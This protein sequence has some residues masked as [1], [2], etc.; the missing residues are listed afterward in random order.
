[1]GNNRKPDTHT[2]NSKT[3][4]ADLKQ[5]ADREHRVNITYKFLT[6]NAVSLF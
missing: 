4:H 6:T 1:M 5:N 2:Y 3:T